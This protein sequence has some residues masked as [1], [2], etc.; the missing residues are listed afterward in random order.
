M[1]INR[2]GGVAAVRAAGSPECFASAGWAC[3][4]AGAL[5]AHVYVYVIYM[6]IYIYIY[7]YIYIYVCVCVYVY[8]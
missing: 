5:Y 3:C 1:F 7:T 8:T 4:V 2:G 6:Y